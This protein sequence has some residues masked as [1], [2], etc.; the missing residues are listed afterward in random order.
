[1]R[2]WYRTRMKSEGHRGSGQCYHCLKLPSYKRKI[3]GRD[4]LPANLSKGHLTVLASL[5]ALH[6][7]A[8]SSWD[9]IVNWNVPLRKQ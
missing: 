8:K 5:L 7:F 1:M 4:M 3:R 6:S 2:C 9:T